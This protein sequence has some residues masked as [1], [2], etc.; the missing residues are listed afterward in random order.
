MGTRA[1]VSRMTSSSAA[2]KRSSGR[3]GDCGGGDGQA[4]GITKNA[5]LPSRNSRIGLSRIPRRGQCLEE[6]AAACLL[7][8]SASVN[9]RQKTAELL[10]RG[11]FWDQCQSTEETGGKRSNG[12]ESS[13]LGNITQSK[14]QGNSGRSTASPQSVKEGGNSIADG[15]THSVPRP[16]VQAAQN[17]APRQD[18][19]TPKSVRSRQAERTG[20]KFANFGESSKSAVTK[21][22]YARVEEER[23]AK[24][25]Q[26]Q[27]LMKRMKDIRQGLDDDAEKS[28]QRRRELNRQISE[29]NRRKSMDSRSKPGR[30]EGPLETS[31]H[32]GRLPTGED[33]E[34]RRERARTYRE[35]LDRQIQEKLRLELENEREED[36]EHGH[37]LERLRA[38]V[39]ESRQQDK[40][41]KQT[42][43]LRLKNDLESQIEENQKCRA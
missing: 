25:L 12:C 17:A 13:T 21:A 35:A 32:V 6:S 16:S 14:I 20:K 42:S 19:D 2:S 7:T 4:G 43:K 37:H 30:E 15:E 1:A 27:E 5:S 11:N 31:F 23:R 38:A 22:A 8:T 9:T 34:R 36:E 24:D 40:M 3:H 41:R 29:Y 10:G 39:L 26:V 33:I 18:A 28:R